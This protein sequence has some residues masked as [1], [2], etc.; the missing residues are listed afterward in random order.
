MCGDDQVACIR[1]VPSLCM[2]LYY[3]NSGANNNA[4]T[5]IADSK[6]QESLRTPAAS[7]SSQAMFLKY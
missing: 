7:F 6:T 4:Y 2:Q 3:L 1:S 5:V